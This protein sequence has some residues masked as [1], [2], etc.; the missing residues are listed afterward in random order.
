MDALSGSRIGNSLSEAL[1]LSNPGSAR[2]AQQQWQQLDADAGTKRQGGQQAAMPA[3]RL[4]AAERAGEAGEL[5]P[6]GRFLNLRV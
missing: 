6:R 5:H 4:A 2:V 3:P 1:G